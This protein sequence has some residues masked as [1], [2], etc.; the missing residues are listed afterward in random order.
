MKKNSLEDI[1]LLRARLIDPISGLDQT[2]DIFIRNGKVFHDR[3]K[4]KNTVNVYDLGGQIIIP[5]LLD[6]R[7]HNRVPGAVKSESIETLTKAAARGGFSSI[8]AMPDTVP[9]SDNPATIR[10]IQDRI[11]QTSKIKVYLSGCLTVGSLGEN[12]APLGSLK[13]VG[14]IAVTDCPSTPSNNQIFKN[15]IRYAKM[16]GLKVIDFPQD[17][18]LSQNTHA[19]E[20]PLS[21]KMGLAGNPRMA[22]EIAVQRSILMSRH[23]GVPIHLSS[24]SSAGSVQQVKQAKEDGIMVT[25]DVSA[26]HLLLTEN[27]ISN[28]NTSAKMN[29]PLRQE[30]DKMALIEGITKG[31]I[32]AC[33]SSHEPYADH[34]KNVEFDLSPSGSIG[35][36]T[37]ALSFI[38]ALGAVEIK[39]PFH[40]L[41][42][43]MSSNPHKI[44]GLEPPSL[45]DGSDANLT[46]IKTN[47]PWQY[48]PLEGESASFNTPVRNFEFSNKVMLSMSNGII[49]YKN[50]VLKPE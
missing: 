17:A 13:D 36:E 2:S 21:L 11:K 24:L 7:A 44:L 14:V 25:A 31:I 30:Q 42:Q 20:S 48:N 28:Y 43:S 10:Y 9:R 18:F 45:I 33:N 12:I 3:P 49:A 26:H 34:L 32:D 16:F 5:G 22:E 46:V 23:L 19:H 15:A 27:E 37:A 40:L 6:L 4:G 1:D 35:L 39:N 41:A 29:P 47:A 38:E 50:N 8:L